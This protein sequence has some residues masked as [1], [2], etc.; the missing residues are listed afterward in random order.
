MYYT[1]D[2]IPPNLAMNGSGET[3]VGL[4]NQPTGVKPAMPA[5]VSGGG[6]GAKRRTEIQTCLIVYDFAHTL[7]HTHSVVDGGLQE[8]SLACQSS[9]VAEWCV[10]CLTKCCYMKHNEE[11]YSFFI[12]VDVI[13]HPLLDFKT[14]RVVCTQCNPK[15]NQSR[16]RNNLERSFFFFGSLA[17]DLKRLHHASVSLCS[18]YTIPSLS[19]KIYVY[20]PG[21]CCQA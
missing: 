18:T 10:V 14:K 9:R 11:S 21:I 1:D 19:L 12:N 5:K 4:K 17:V 16:W 7:S 15:R 8:R 6:C 20:T 3:V 2:N 13:I